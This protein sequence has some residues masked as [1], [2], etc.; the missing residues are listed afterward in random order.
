MGFCPNRFYP[1]VAALKSPTS[2]LKSSLWAWLDQ[3]YHARVHGETGQTPFER[4][5]AGI[6]QIR[7]VD[8][9]T[10]RLAFQWRAK[11]K[12]NQQ[13][14]LSF[15][16][17]TYH[18]D[19]RWC[20]QVIELRFDP[21]DLSRIDLYDP[22]GKHLGLATLRVHKRQYHLDIQRLVPEALRHSP[23]AKTDFLKTLR[24]EYAHALRER[25]GTIRF[26]NLPS[27]GANPST[28]DCH[29]F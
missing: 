2:H 16:G 6:D 25:I 11:R 29:P 18:V 9:E 22:H 20:G 15:Q 10:L 21:F 12:V 13:A 14:T 17:N 26:A 8:P 28:G 27:A 7:T 5:A 4:F 23:P 24:Q 1:E 19:P 3:V